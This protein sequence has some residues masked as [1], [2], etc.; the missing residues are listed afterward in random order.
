M[1]QAQPPHQPTP[2]DRPTPAEVMSRGF[3]LPYGA[4]RGGFRFYFMAF[5]ALMSFGFY[6]S[7]AHRLFLP[8]GL[9]SASV[10][11]YFFPL[12]EGRPRIGANEY[13]IFCDGLGLIPWREVNDILLRTFAVRN[14]ENK[15]LHIQLKRDLDH[16]LIAD[17]RRQPLWRILMKLPWKLGADN[18]IR[19]KLEPFPMEPERIHNTMTR[20]WRFYG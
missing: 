15:E 5:V 9:A 14:M 16:A 17:W 19:I 3:A 8:I 12:I 1:A 2:D 4:N 10:A 7:G 6:V 11:Y 18:L 20:L 13:G